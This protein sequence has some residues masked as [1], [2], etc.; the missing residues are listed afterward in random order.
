MTH[1]SIVHNC[2]CEDPQPTVKVPS[3]NLAPAD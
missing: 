2:D 3:K 1:T